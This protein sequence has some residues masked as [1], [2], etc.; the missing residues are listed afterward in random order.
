MVDNLV[1]PVDEA[2]GFA[3][4]YELHA[5]VH[6]ENPAGVFSPFN[7]AATCAHHAGAHNH[8]AQ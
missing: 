6:R 1:T 5:W 4:H 3:P 7:T 2:H 8:P